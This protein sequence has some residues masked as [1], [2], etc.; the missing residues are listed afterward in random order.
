VCV[1]GFNRK[2]R[3]AISARLFSRLFYSGGLGRQMKK[4]GTGNKQ[5]GKSKKVKGKTGRRR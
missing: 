4:E 2:S 3:L 1:Q 5:Q